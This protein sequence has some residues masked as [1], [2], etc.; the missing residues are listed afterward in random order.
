MSAN[1]KRWA[2]VSGLAAGAGVLLTAFVLGATSLRAAA[3]NDQR[4]SD[5]LDWSQRLQVEPR[6]VR[7]EQCVA[8]VKDRLDR[9]ESKLDRLIERGHG[10]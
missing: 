10:E 2:Q 1:G 9:I 7:A 8:E 6:L 5:H 4:L 3:Q